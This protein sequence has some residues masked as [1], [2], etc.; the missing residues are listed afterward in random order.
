M[1]QYLDNRRIFLTGAISGALAGLVAFIFA[2]IFAEPQIQLAIDYEGA[3]DEVQEAV[4]KL[5]AAAGIKFPEPGPDIEIFSRGIQRNIG[6]ATGMVLMGLAFG[7]LIA[8]AFRLIL[9]L[10]EGRPP[11]SGRLTLVL[12]GLLGWV[13]VFAVPALKYPPNPPAIGHYFTIHQRGNLYLLTVLSSVVL[14]IGAAFLARR[15]AKTMNVWTAVFIAGAGYLAVIGIIF[16]L[17]PNLGSL[18]QNV[19]YFGS[20]VTYGSGDA[21]VTIPV[22]TETPLALRDPS[23]NYLFPGFPAD[24]LSRFRLY[25]F[26]AQAILWLGASLIMGTWLTRVPKGAVKHQNATTAVGV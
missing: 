21:A 1:I 15:L 7:L 26:I 6:I 3:R 18:S 4:D 22:T 2:R 10:T 23:G 9:Q 5:N 16:A 17:L 11:L 8:I 20:S 14:A 13:V 25:S 24:V 19:Q 12:I